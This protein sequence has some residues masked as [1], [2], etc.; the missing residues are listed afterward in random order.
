MVHEP[1]KKWI[2]RLQLNEKKSKESKT[3]LMGWYWKANLKEGRIICNKVVILGLRFLLIHW[4]SYG[5]GALFKTGRPRSRGWKNF[6][7]NGPGRWGVL[8]NG[9]FMYAICASSL[10]FIKEIT[11]P[12]TQPCRRPYWNFY[13]Y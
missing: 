8:K 4:L 3:R 6:D 12:R 5:E 13:L 10:K 1:L 9:Q 11:E 7:V 2:V